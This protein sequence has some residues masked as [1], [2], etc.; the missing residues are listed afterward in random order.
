MRH[1]TARRCNQRHPRASMPVSGRSCFAVR[2][3]SYTLRQGMLSRRTI[4]GAGS[5]II[6]DNFPRTVT[7]MRKRAEEPHQ[8]AGQ[9]C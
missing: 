6:P 3:A 5:T 1:G 2:R 9:E 4:G 8:T 7:T